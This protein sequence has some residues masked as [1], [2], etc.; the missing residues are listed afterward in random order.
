MNPATTENLKLIWKLSDNNYKLDNT[1]SNSL[2]IEYLPFNDL[3]VIG[4]DE[5]IMLIKPKNILKG[6]CLYKS[7]Y[8]IDQDKVSFDESTQVIYPLKNHYTIKRKIKKLDLDKKIHNKDLSGFVTEIIELISK[9][10]YLYDIQQF[11]TLLRK[12]NVSKNKAVIKQMF[13]FEREE[14]IYAIIVNNLM[15]VEVINFNL[16]NNE[17]Q[18]IQIEELSD[19]NYLVHKIYVDNFEKQIDKII[20]CAYVSEIKNNSE[21]SILLAI[22]YKLSERKVLRNSKHH[23]PVNI[24][25]MFLVKE[26]VLLIKSSDGK[27]VCL[28]IWDKLTKTRKRDKNNYKQLVTKALNIETPVFIDYTIRIN[29]GLVLLV[30]FGKIYSLDLLNNKSDLIY[31]DLE[32]PILDIKSRGND[33]YFLVGLR[34]VILKSQTLNKN[35]GTKEEKMNKKVTKKALNDK[36]IK[37]KHQKSNSNETR[38]VQYSYSDIFEIFEYD[39]S[40]YFVTVDRFCV[41]YS[42]LNF[43][44]LGTSTKYY[45]SKKDLIALSTGNLSLL[46]HSNI[47]YSDLLYT[48]IFDVCIS[49]E[50]K[51]INSFYAAKANYLFAYNTKTIIEQKFFK[52]ALLKMHF[53]A[54]RKILDILNDKDTEYNIVDISW[55]LL[56]NRNGSEFYLTVDTGNV[57]PTTYGSFK[58][59]IKCKS[60]YEKATSRRCFIC[61]SRVL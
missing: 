61:L 8:N 15:K 17:I 60:V 1:N 47:K 40:N 52:Q 28:N 6:R 23:V 48:N 4:K 30:S 56:N 39:L 55:C 29:E 51:G 31:E 50:N 10:E 36:N 20:I 46:D 42:G 45:D 53:T 3:I 33:F 57:L 9:K 49:K 44:I 12:E 27:M 41:S 24:Q 54:D 16:L 19:A 58:Y 25:D 5:T 26:D 2:Y 34:L 7:I 43:F 32:H 21:N 14:Y 38:R 13:V 37:L 11:E 35:E 22:E 59:C 18:S